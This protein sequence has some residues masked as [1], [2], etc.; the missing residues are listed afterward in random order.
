QGLLIPSDFVRAV[1]E[2]YESGESRVLHGLGDFLSAGRVLLQAKEQLEHGEFT[3]QVLTRTRCGPRIAQMLM[4]VAKHP[5]T[6]QGNEPGSFLPPSWRTL[7]ELSRIE[8]EKLQE[9]IDDGLISPSMSRTE[10]IGLRRELPRRS[11]P[12]P[13]LNE[14]VPG[15]FAPPP[16]READLRDE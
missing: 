3:K 4:S 8:P 14:F 5:L 6:S 16:R 1:D 11:R 10:A 9:A 7:Y 12:S 13:T 2:L 15:S